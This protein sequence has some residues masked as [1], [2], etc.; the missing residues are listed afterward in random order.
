MSTHSPQR[1]GRAIATVLLTAAASASAQDSPCGLAVDIGQPTSGDSTEIKAIS[2]DGSTLAGASLSG[3]ALRWTEQGGYQFLG[4]LPGFTDSVAAA[5]NQDGSVIVGSAFASSGGTARPFRWTDSGGMQGLGTP[6]SI[7]KALA[8]R[9]S[10]DGQV[11]TGEARIVV[12]TFGEEAEQVLVWTGSGAPAFVIPPG[13]SFSRLAALSGDGTT[14]A[15]VAFDIDFDPYGSPFST[16]EQAFTW[17]SAAGYTRIGSLNDGFEPVDVSL[18]GAVV[19][20]RPGP[21]GGPAVWTATGGFQAVPMTLA[22]DLNDDGT[23]VSGSLIT[24]S[25]FLACRWSGLTGLEVLGSPPGGRAYGR[26]VSDDGEVVSGEARTASSARAAFRWSVNGGWEDLGTGMDFCPKAMAGDGRTL[27]GNTNFGLKRGIVW[28][29]TQ[30]GARYCTGVTNSTGRVA[31]LRT[32]GDLGAAANNF[33]LFATRVPPNTFGYFL[34]SRIQTPPT[35]TAGSVGLL[36]LGG[37]IGRFVGPGQI[38]S[39][40]AAGSDGTGSFAL[41]VDLT[42]LPTGQAFAS[43]QAGDTWNFQGWYRDSGPTTGPSNFTDAVSVTF[44]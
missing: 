25:Q 34:T 3:G 14:V 44:L 17:S 5:V 19:L 22:Y 4:T 21:A 18:N 24:G 37:P 23:V 8:H 30:I 20:G 36:C 29:S 33:T 13:S 10:R 40:G 15:G 39:S 28:G 27:A 1:S 7:S 16:N 2:G 9:V 11:V 41:P 6:A 42:Q 35:P 31:A 32:C 43:A 26:F 12:G 38:L